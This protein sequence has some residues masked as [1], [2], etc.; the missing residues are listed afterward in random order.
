MKKQH[1]ATNLLMALMLFAPSVP[2]SSCSSARIIAKDGSV[3]STRTMEFG[4]E[5]GYGLQAVPKGS[6]FTSPAP[7]PGKKGLQ[8]ETSYN[9]F[10]VSVFGDEGVLIDGMND[11]GLSASGLWFE[12]DTKWPDL[13]DDDSKTLAHTHFISWALGNCKDVTD[14]KT[15]LRDVKLFALFLPQMKM[16]PPLHFE[17]DDA[18]G[19]SI[20]VE[21]ADGKINIYDN[22]TG[23]LT[24]AP[25]FPFMLNNLRNYVGMKNMVP[26]AR[27]FGSYLARPTGHGSGMFGLPGDLTPPSR[28]ARLA[29]QIQTADQAADAKSLLN[30]AQH[31]ANTVDIIRGMAVD[32][33]A[34][35]EII[36]SETTQWTAFRDL[37]SKVWYYRTY[38]NPG[39]RMVDLKTLDFKDGKIKKAP[40][41]GS[42]ETIADAAPLL[43]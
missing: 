30:L 36:S 27:T 18:S 5:V 42:Q 33:N 35:G 23:V 28:F 39:L 20:V 14:V 26:D 3:M 10:G 38:D 24:N 34:A 12:P 1:I 37:S 8:W 4:Y 7:V 9:Y 16:A 6:K 22:P 41:Y 31:L 15:K 43:K 2:V 13:K 19:A 11:A 21:A 25:D 40:L 17:L 32:R 29:V